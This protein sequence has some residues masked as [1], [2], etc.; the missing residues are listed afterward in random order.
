MLTSEAFD[1]A[2]T[3]PRPPNVVYTGPRLA[4]P[5]WARPWTPPPGDEPLVLVSL[6]STYQD[7]V[8]M[9]R[10]IADA[11]GRLPVRGLVTAGPSVDAS[12]VAAPPNVSVVA[13]APHDAVLRQAAAVIGHGGHGT[14]IK[15]LAHGVPVVAVPMG[16][17]QN[18]IAA[19][20]VAS[21]AGLGSRRAPSVAASARRSSGCSPSPL[22]PPRPRRLQAAIADDLAEDRAVD[23]LERLAVRRASPS[24][25]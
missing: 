22:S 21:G 6:S 4:D 1:F 3:G 20:V 7:Q 24:L 10:A 19:R 2:P 14:T 25:A 18:D 15:A 5:A 13:S 9:L 8:P 16:R 23:E 12:A 11:L 17:D